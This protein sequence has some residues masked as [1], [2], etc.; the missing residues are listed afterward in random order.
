MKAGLCSCNTNCWPRKPKIIPTWSFIEKVSDPTDPRSVPKG[1]MSCA[2]HQ[3]LYGN[4]KLLPKMAAQIY[5]P[6]K[7][8]WEFHFLHILTS[9]RFA[10]VLPGASG[11]VSQR[12]F[13]FGSLNMYHLFIYQTSIQRLL[14][15]LCNP[16]TIKIKLPHVTRGDT[17]LSNV[18]ITSQAW[19][20]GKMVACRFCCHALER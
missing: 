16:G 11:W 3:F 8:V 14:C 6:W 4:A 19:W 20:W 15:N 17:E 13:T 1:R 18:R 5:P 7:R 2:R 9:Q 10:S 12:Y